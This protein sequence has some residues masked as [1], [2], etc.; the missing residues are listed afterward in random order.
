MRKASAGYRSVCNHSG[1]MAWLR[2]GR[3][4]RLLSPPH[5]AI[6]S[7]KDRGRQ[8]RAQCKSVTGVQNPSRANSPRSREAPEPVAFE[9]LINTRSY[10]RSSPIPFSK[11]LGIHARLLWDTIVV[12]KTH[13]APR[14]TLVRPCASGGR[15]GAVICPFRPTGVKPS[16]SREEAYVTDCQ[17]TLQAGW[18]SAR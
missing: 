15:P 4:A 1:Q 18:A 5:D 16:P 13:A 12:C 9:P 14:L 2:P 8:R 7:S 11:A 6:R 3:H 10:G 17:G